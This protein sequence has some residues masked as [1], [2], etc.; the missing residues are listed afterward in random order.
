MYMYII[1]HIDELNKIMHVLQWYIWWHLNTPSNQITP[2]FS[3]VNIMIFIPHMIFSW[4]I[5]C[6]SR[7]TAI[8]ADTS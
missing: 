3:Y 7:Y 2:V 6:F 4:G 1:D 8:Y 5:L